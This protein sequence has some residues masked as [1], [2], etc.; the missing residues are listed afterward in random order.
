MARKSRELRFSQT[1]LLIEEYSSAGIGHAD[2]SFRFM[3]D[4]LLR[5][6]HN[7]GL[8]KGQRNYL[9][10]LIEQGVPKPK[11]EERV[12][13]ILAASNVDGMQEVSATLKDFA[14]KLGRGWSLSEKQENFLKSLLDKSKKLQKEGRYRPDTETVDDLHL[15]VSLL[16]HKNSWYWQHRIGT[17]KA[18]DKVQSWLQWTVRKKAIDDLRD[19][20]PDTLVSIEDEPIINQWSCDKVLKTVKNQIHEIKNPRHPSGAMAWMKTYGQSG[21]STKVLGLVSGLPSIQRGVIVYPFLID[22]EDIMVPT[23]QLKKRR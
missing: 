16:Q 15:A 6:E 23:D 17:S 18:F 2:R 12:N 8:S 10:S 20:N 4:M 13:Q 11:N 5:L 7:K 9:D 3:N 19:C 21:K 14:Y 22:G 1:K